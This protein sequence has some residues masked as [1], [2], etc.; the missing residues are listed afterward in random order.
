MTKEAWEK[1]KKQANININFDFENFGDY[2]DNEGKL[3]QEKAK[4]YFKKAKIR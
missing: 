4:E 2:F 3:I 1:I